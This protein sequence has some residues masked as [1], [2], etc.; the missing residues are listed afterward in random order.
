[1]K[2]P[3][4]KIISGAQTGVDRAA[5]DAARSW[6]LSGRAWCPRGRRAEDNIPAR[7]A[8]EETASCAYEQRTEWNVRDSDATL[9]ICAGAPDPG[10][11][12]TQEMIKKWQKPSLIVDLDQNRHPAISIRT[13]LKMSTIRVLNIAGPRESQVPGIHE[14]TLVVLQQILSTMFGKSPLKSKRLKQFDEVAVYPVSCERL[15]N[16]HSDESVL[17]AVIAGGA[18][19]IQL[20]DKYAT[21]K[22]LQKKAERFRELTRAHGVLLIINDHIDLAI[23]VDADGVHLGQKDGSISQARMRIRDKLLG[24]S[25]HSLRQARQAETDGADYI[26]IGP[27]FSTRTKSSPMTPMGIEMIEAIR[28]QLRIPFTVMGGI[29][30]HNIDLVLSAG[31]KKIAMIT[32]ITQAVD[33]TNTVRTF[34]D[35]IRY[36]TSKKS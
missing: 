23:T 27:I 13:W 28:A 10:T 5:L 6:H 3:D 4:F 12:Y 22:D 34:E 1:M 35:R 21:R 9:I 15:S 31:A 32:A 20:R 2:K 18:K 26:N 17:E 25:T 33:I 16:G 7:Y 24:V 36:Y 30:E 8:V 14:R 19:I 29:H 11:T